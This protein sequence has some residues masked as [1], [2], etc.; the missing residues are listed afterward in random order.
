AMLQGSAVTVGVL[1][2]WG[3][4]LLLLYR[5]VELPPI[6]LL[7][8]AVVGGLLVIGL[9]VQFIVRPAL[10]RIP[11]ERIALLIEERV[12][13][14]QDR[15]NSAVEIDDPASARRAHGILV[16][17]LID[18]AAERARSVPLTTV[19]DRHRERMLAGASAIAL[20]FFLILG[21]SA[22]DD[23]RLTIGSGSLSELMP[24]SL[25]FMTIDPGDVEIERGG[26]QDVVVSLRE[27]TDRD[28]VINYRNADGEWQREVMRPAIGQP[29][30]LH[31]FVSVQQPLE[32][33]V[34]HDEQRS[35]VFT[36][37]LY[38]FPSVSSIDVTYAYPQYTGMAPETEEGTGD[39]F[40]LRGSDVSIDVSTTGNAVEGELVRDDGVRIP[41][42]RT[43]AGRFRALMKLDFEGLYHIRLV[44]DQGK[45]NKFPDEYQVIPIDDQRPRITITDPQ[46]DVRANAI[47]EVLMAVRVEDDFGIED[48]RLRFAVNAGEEQTVVLND[49]RNERAREV[50]GEH[51]FFLEDYALEPGDVI[52][53]FVEAEDAFH[54]SP[55]MSDMYFIEV[56]PFDQE[57]RQVT[58][59]GMQGGG[60][61]SAIV[62]NQQQIIAATWRL[63][64]E[65]DRMNEEE[66]ESSRRALV[67]AQESLRGNI[68]ERI[69]STAFSV[70]L[71]TDDDSRRV[72][73]LLRSAV[74]AMGGAVIELNANR[75][76]EALT[77]ER[78][79]LNALLKADALN[80]EQNVAL[81][82][83][84][85]G[86]GGGGATEERM[87]ELMDL[88]LDISK[89]KYEVLP[90]RSGQS[91]GAGGEMDEALQRLRELSRRQQN[92]ANQSRQELEG[93]E[94]RRQVERLTRDQDE[95]RREAQQLARQ[96]RGMQSR[97][98]RSSEEAR[99][100]LERITRNMQEAQEALRD[101]DV[102]RARARQQQAVNELERMT[103][104]M[105][106]A[107][108][109]GRREALQEMDREFDGMREQEEALARD[110]QRAAR[111]AQEEDRLDAEGLEELAERRRS[112]REALERFRELVER[113]AEEH[114]DTPEIASAARNLRQGL[115]REALEEQM[116]DSERAIVRGW[117]DNAERRQESI[118]RGMERLEQEMRA[119]EGQLPVTDEERLARSMQSLRELERELERLR[120]EQAGP[121]SGDQ[122]T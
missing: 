15:L 33:F 69:S 17:R 22:I 80:R 79:A 68:Q 57:Y 72:V 47:E 55:E 111:E 104:D 25:P 2:G 81:N 108:N 113:V 102:D 82:R 43:D 34:Q 27:E 46:R 99:E 36:V 100:Q 109:D 98:G 40:G 59:G 76:R 120:D 70:E 31:E 96:M 93:E 61:Q 66:F 91:A 3:L 37:S 20:A 44:D 73:E 60:G 115:R 103:R 83:G 88:E 49:A 87:T 21:Y 65:R 29:D 48:V 16:D 8:L 53:Y 7:V 41:L 64:R 30:Y 118:R 54:E 77:P 107:T 26:S 63:V 23:V 51:L 71:Q 122:Q 86:G 92:L 67:Q 114:A 35:D 28:V 74:E 6:V 94:Q 52:S 121:S 50:E 1:A 4:G 85:Q 32:Y 95:L 19:V 97:N 13:E 24:V 45:E 89:D 117:L 62:L 106:V 119:F 112:N 14:L 116:D 10:R 5:V 11:D 90:E 84:N 9:G 78:E 42:E 58:A 56:I 105:R 12:P 18:D 39:I 101:G 110:L 38:T 75:L